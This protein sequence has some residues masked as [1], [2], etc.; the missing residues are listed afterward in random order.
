MATDFDV[1]LINFD[2]QRKQHISIAERLQ[3]IRDCAF[4]AQ[5]KIQTKP[6]IH[7]SAHFK[8]I[9]LAPEYFFAA[10]VSSQ[11]H[12]LGD[13]RQLD[14]D[15]KLEIQ[16]RMLEISAN[17]APDL[18]I[19]PGTI[20]WRKP[21]DRSF[22]SFARRQRRKKPSISELDL[23][24]LWNIK[25]GFNPR[26]EKAAQEI[27][28]TAKH[29]YKAKL[30]FYQ[31]QLHGSFNETTLPE[32]PPAF[33][34]PGTTNQVR[35]PQQKVTDI[36][37]HATHM[38]RSTAYAFLKGQQVARYHKQGDFFEV[39]SNVDRE[40]FVPGPYGKEG[41]TPE[42]W[43]GG[44]SFGIEIC[45]DHGLGALKARR[46]STVDVHILLSAHLEATA[47]ANRAKTGGC[48]AHASSMHSSAG[49]FGIDS[50][51]RL[52]KR[53]DPWEDGPSMQFFRVQIR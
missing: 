49:V 27:E 11:N 7:P 47:H 41:R 22:E 13:I 36:R 32:S 42:F 4:Y 19:I 29:L 6:L 30:G 24:I 38:A 9:L 26:R 53:A 39:L 10:P 52:M 37:S 50:H 21:L 44:I 35:T 15:Q 40:V 46:G 2:T 8:G 17:I 31:P 23:Q 45:Y 51:G 25:E 34:L 43:L 16:L 33:N 48:L 18:L 3:F 28:R 20:A 1:I 14:E 12:A 5:G